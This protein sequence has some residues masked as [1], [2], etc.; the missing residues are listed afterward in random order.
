L[1]QGQPAK[2]KMT[3]VCGHVFGLDFNSKFNN[4]DKTDPAELFVCQAEKKETTPKLKMPNFLAS[5]GKGSDFLVLWLDCDKEGENICFEVV[6]CVSELTKIKKSNIL[7]AHFS[8]ITDK[9]I[10]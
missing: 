1:L 10:R 8:S 7:R 6:E 5:E 4:W 3:S 9:D 2:F